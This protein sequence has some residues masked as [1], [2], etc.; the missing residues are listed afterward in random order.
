MSI[1]RRMTVRTA[2]SVVALVG[3][4]GLSACSDSSDDAATTTS[5]G[6]ELLPAAEGNT[7]YPLELESPWGSTTLEERPVRIAAVTP[8]QI[9]V[10][11]LAALG[12]TPHLANENADDV[13]VMD[14]LPGAIVERYSSD[15][16]DKFPAEQIAAADPDLIIA[17]ESDLTESYDRLATIAPV[18]TSEN[19]SSGWTASDWRDNI[20]RI[21]EA[22]DLS[23]AAAAVITEHEEWFAEFREQHPDIAGKTASY[24]VYYGTEDGLQYHSSADA[25]LMGVFEQM[26]LV[27]GAGGVG[28]AYRQAISEELLSTIDADVIIFSDNSDGNSGAIIDTPLFQALDAAKQD[29]VLVL[30]NQGGTYVIDGTTYDGNLPWALARSGP[31]SSKFAASALAEPLELTLAK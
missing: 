7:A 29:H 24:V 10:E 6:S 22:I 20:T 17:L 30:E 9:D 21:G 27:Q 12:V 4:L 1:R 5:T 3:T 25:D 8:S 16:D 11:M 13:W 28:V 14:A 2:L 18:L 15:A 19:S 26:G 31:L 23:D